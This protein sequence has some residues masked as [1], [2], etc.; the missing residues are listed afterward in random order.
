MEQVLVEALKEGAWRE[1]AAIDAALAR[2]EIDEPGWHAAIQALIVPAYLGAD[3][4][5][6]QSGAGGDAARWRA[7]RRV[8]LRAVD[9]DGD[10]LDIGCANGYLM[11]SLH[12]WAAGVGTAVEPYGLDLSPEL[13]AL[14]RRRLPHWADRIWVG[15][16][17]HWVPPRRFDY[18][19]TGLEYVPA[20]RRADL[21]G[22]LMEHAVGR[23]LIVGV[24]T[25]ETGR[26]ALE[27]EVAAYGYPVAGRY[28][29]AHE[30]PRVARRLFWIDA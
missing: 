13:A 4:P 8:L 5:W 30:D 21:L 25:E 16:A 20:H 12:A 23:R 1:V 2:G 26:R 29:S 28:E 18:V 24:F 17:L 15:N 7:K 10:L 11:E 9:R 27:G 3:T 22:H 6:G 14:A 19:R